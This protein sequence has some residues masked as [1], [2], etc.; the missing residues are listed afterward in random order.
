MNTTI[1]QKIVYK[2]VSALLLVVML[3]AAL[4]SASLLP[5]VHA[6]AAS[7]ITMS[8]ND[9]FTVREDYLFDTPEKKWATMVSDYT[10]TY[11]NYEMRIDP[12]SGEVAIK[13]VRT[14]EILFSNP[15]D[16]TTLPSDGAKRQ[17]L[18]QLV[19]TYRLK[20]G[21][22]DEKMYSF[23]A[24]WYD[25]VKGSSAAGNAS[26]ENAKNQLTVN[27]IRNGF[28]VEYSMGEE[29]VRSVTPLRISIERFH[30]MIWDKLPATEQAKWKVYPSDNWPSKYFHKPDTYMNMQT[31]IN[32]T[33]AGGAPAVYELLTADLNGIQLKNIETAIKTHCPDYTYEERMADQEATLY[34][35]TKAAK[36]LFKM[37]IEYRLGTEGLTVRLPANSIRFDESNFE[38]RTIA[39]LPYFGAGDINNEGYTFLPDGSGALLSY[40]AMSGGTITSDMYGNDYAYHKLEVA[41]G[42]RQIARLPV[43]GTATTFD[44]L[45]DYEYIYNSETEKDEL[46]PVYGTQDRGFVAIIEEGVAMASITA[47]RGDGKQ[48]KYCTAY[49]VFSPRPRDEYS[50]S[51]A[52]GSGQ[53]A[54]WSVFSDR[55][56]TGSYQIRFVML[57]DEELATAAGVNNFY[58]CTYVG[59]ANAY[60][61]YLL[62][63]Q[64]ISKLDPTGV[65]DS[66]PFYME[67]LG[68]IDTED[69]IFSFPVTVKT[70]L[71]TFEDVKKMYNG[72]KDNGI[73]NV[74][75]RL[76]GYANGGITGTIP[77][78]VD[79]EDDLGGDE[80][81]VDFLGF[82]AQNGIGVYP[83]F[84]FAYLHADAFF[85]GFTF[86]EDAAKTIDDRYTQ[87][88]VY[89][90]VFQCFTQT[91][92]SVISPSAYNRFFAM[93]SEE[94]AQFYTADM[95]TQNIGVSVSTL[96]SDLN[97]DFD[98]DAPYNRED[99]RGFTQHM[100]KNLEKQFGNVMVDGGNSYALPYVTHVL[101]ISLDSSRDLNQF[102]SVPFFGIVFH[103]YLSYAGTPTNMASSSDYESLK[104]VEN[105]AAPY[106]ILAYQNTSKLKD[107]PTLAKYYSISYEFWLDD[108]VEI[109]TELNAVLADLQTSL[110]TDH[111]FLAGERIRTADEIA[112]EEAVAATLEGDEKDAY[113][114][115]CA[116]N[117]VVD[118][119]TIVKV[120]YENG[121]TFYLN[122]NRQF[123]VTVD[124]YEIPAL[125]FIRVDAVKNTSLEMAN[126]YASDATYCYN[127]GETAATATIA[128]KDYTVAAQSFL[129]HEVLST[130]TDGT[131]V[132]CIT[133]ANGARTIFNYTT[134]S[135]VLAENGQ[136]IP[137]ASSAAV[138]AA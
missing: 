104:I 136:E 62:S 49:T 126:V 28:L 27:P 43:F 121:A 128:G 111:R 50:L 102:Q 34:V 61:D 133:D 23:N 98:E 51:S 119:G 76:N 40:N 96:G 63:N 45:L 115:R 100:L 25:R 4:G 64:Y 37:A 82:A 58:D 138:A 88:Q 129:K 38:L 30:E 135:Y 103:G 32:V 123:A 131:T 18:S 107:N 95:K 94:M 9:Y 105:G 13:D 130:A 53:D 92:L 19:V 124:G 67:T 109:Y 39:L 54:M 55:K 87:K 31:G 86:K 125:S 12:L 68:V 44:G 112:Y 74:V 35:E 66:L 60:R 48:H 69:T 47:E 26:E 137:A 90:P 89:D 101:N 134:Q 113:L 97:S 85:D 91:G 77:Y 7:P 93:F 70:P 42:N 3:F 56:Y 118:N 5:A 84:D 83:E 29:E 57:Q 20:G 127:K 41:T 72:L 1:K 24:V 10:T 17:L 16:L 52:I 33:V 11:G 8:M 46:T 6:A 65:K 22:T 78:Y 132:V 120:V 79:F 108:M 116:K 117:R 36:P 80:G 106:F 81:F 2:L 73:S 59:M 99:T 110:I 122:Y 114:E 14:G 15:Y 75:V 71:T 21:K